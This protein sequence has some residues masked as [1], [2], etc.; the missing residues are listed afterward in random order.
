M[1]DRELTVP[2]E[3]NLEAAS[4]RKSNK[5]SKSDA[6]HNELSLAG[7][8]KRNGWVVHDFTFEVG[9]LGWVA[10]STRQ[11]LY[12]LGFRSSHLNWLVKRISKVTMRS[13]YL[14]WCC[15]KQ[16]S[17]EPPE[18]V[19]LRTA[20]TTDPPRDEG[21]PNMAQQPI[22]PNQEAALNFLATK[23]SISAQPD[24][25]IEPSEMPL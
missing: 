4:N 6:K 2:L 23:I 12:K 25:N 3:E 15:R 11:F 20:S 5:Y 17:W 18:L 13:S 1:E 16:R 14:I 24:A 22:N 10:H 8:C 19:P 7:E 21:F 9:S